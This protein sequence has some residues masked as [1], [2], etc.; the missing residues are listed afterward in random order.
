MKAPFLSVVMPVH[1]A[2]PFLDESIGTIVN[3]TFTDFEFVIMDDG[4]TDGSERVLRAWEKKDDRIRVFQ[5]DHK[6]GLAGSSNLVV[7]KARG[8]LIARMDADDI[9]HPDRLRR[10]REVF[11]SRDDVVVVGTLCEGIDA[12]GRPVRP[13]DRWRLVRTNLDKRAQEKSQSAGTQ[14]SQRCRRARVFYGGFS[15]I[16]NVSDS[17]TRTA[18]QSKGFVP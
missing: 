4:S 18:C 11:K 3:Q 10:Q 7:S 17:L 14:A 15:L 6:L 8:R 16:L 9:S 12:K 5:S 13:R 2:L 1:N